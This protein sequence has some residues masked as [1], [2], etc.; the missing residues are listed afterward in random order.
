MEKDLDRW[1]EIANLIEQ[2]KKRALDD[3]HAREFVPGALPPRRPAFL[4][5]LR[6]LL[7]PALAATAAS[8]LLAAG[9]LSYWLLRGNWRKVPAAPAATDLL[10]DS[11]LYDSSRPREIVDEIRADSPFAQALAAWTRAGGSRPAPAPVAGDA[12]PGA[13]VERGDPGEVRRKI[14]R[15]IRERTL[16]RLLTQFHEIHDKE[17]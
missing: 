12:D 16:E 4:S 10:A 14:S 3:F 2:D 6:P 9:L 1:A 11:F 7:R 8:A 13:A 5:G 15:A 17:A